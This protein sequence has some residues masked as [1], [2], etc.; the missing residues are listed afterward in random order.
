MV[1]LAVSGRI[2]LGAAIVGAIVLLVIVFR[3]ER[4]NDD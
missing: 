1:P 3:I 2:V 4:S